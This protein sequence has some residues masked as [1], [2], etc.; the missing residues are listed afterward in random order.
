VAAVLGRAGGHST[1]VPVGPKSEFTTVAWWLLFAVAAFVCVVVIALVIGAAVFRRRAR[2][3]SNTEARGFVLTFGVV[4]PALV[5]AATFA[6]S[7]VGI[8]KQANPSRP[9]ALHISVIGHE[10]WWEVRYPGGAVTANEIHVPVGQPVDV[11]LTTA[12]VIHSF[13]VPEVMP[14]MDMIPGHTNDT[15]FTIDKAGTYRGQCAEYCGIE[16]AHMAFEV[17]AQPQADFTTWLDGQQQDAATP[18]SAEAKRGYD[19]LTNGTCATC[20]TVRGTSADGKVG[21]DLTHVASRSTIGALTVPNDRGNL[22]G[23]IANSQQLKPGNKMPPQ[24]LSPADLNAV[25]SY[26][27]TLR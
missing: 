22:A 18:T 14:K 17:V 5:F 24:P 16:H 10:W 25:V 27:E 6:L 9:A 2:R 15:W 4:I 12:D 3:V 8:A 19:V 13:W 1:L 21:P 11:R 26:L 20:H 7:V 23:W